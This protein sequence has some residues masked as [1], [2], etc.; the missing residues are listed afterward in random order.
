MAKLPSFEK[1]QLENLEER[2]GA[3]KDEEQRKVWIQVLRSRSGAVKDVLV[4]KGG[5]A[6]KGGGGDAGVMA[7]QRS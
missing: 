1:L 5:E 2:S 3:A 6:N 7:G 4:S